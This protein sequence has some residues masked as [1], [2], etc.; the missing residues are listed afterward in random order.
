MQV[1]L[2]GKQIFAHIDGEYRELGYGPPR[3]GMERNKSNKLKEPID[4]TR[5]VSELYKESDH[6]VEMSSTVCRG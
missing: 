2:D 3:N 1:N 6:E 4:I 5:Q